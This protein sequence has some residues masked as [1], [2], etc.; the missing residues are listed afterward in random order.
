MRA[1]GRT[2]EG[3]DGVG[4]RSRRRCTFES[5]GTP[6]ATAIPIR[7]SGTSCGA[8]RA[9][10]RYP[11]RQVDRPCVGSRRERDAGAAADGGERQHGDAVLASLAVADGDLAAVEVEVLDAQ[12]GAFENPEPGTVQDR[13]HQPGGASQLTE[14]QR[15]LGPRE[16]ERN[17]GGPL[18][19]DDLVQSRDR[20]A[21]HLAVEEQ[22]RAE[23]LVLRGGAHL[24]PNGEVR[25]EGGDRG[26]SQFRRMA[27][28]MEHD[29]AANPEHVRVFGATAELPQTDGMPDAI[30]Q[31]GR[32][33][34]RGSAGRPRLLRVRPVPDRGSCCPSRVDPR[35]RSPRVPP[36]PGERPLM[37]KD[38]SLG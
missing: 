23:G 25:E 28:A 29:E 35:F 36:R 14:H 30:E 24:A 11:R 32:P 2:R 26:R 37:R 15:D 17:P 3:G 6:I 1:A 34:M 33:R 20:L 18:R 21:E 31:A 4:F 7:R 8:R 27:L 12:S 16:D 5:P 9:V 19:A 10:R 13:R 38:C 22:Q